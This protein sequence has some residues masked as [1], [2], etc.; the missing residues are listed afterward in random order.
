MRRSASTDEAV[1]GEMSKTAI[2]LGAEDMR[3]TSARPIP[4]KPPIGDAE[5]IL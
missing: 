1:V 2:L 4:D 5:L 3:V